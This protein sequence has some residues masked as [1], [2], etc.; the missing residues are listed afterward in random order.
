MKKASAVL[1]VCLAASLIGASVHAGE[2]SSAFEPYL[3]DFGANEA[4]GAIITMADQVDLDALK[5]D[6][7]AQHADRRA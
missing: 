2:Y 5:A 1:L 4:V 6:L 3:T 7:Y